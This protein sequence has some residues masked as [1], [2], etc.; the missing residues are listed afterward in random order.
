MV[1]GDGINDGSAATASSFLN[2]AGDGDADTLQHRRRDPRHPR[3][4]KFAADYKAKFS[5]DPGA[6]S[7]PAYACTQVFLAALKAVGAAA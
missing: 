6:Y 2:I 7:A 3:P 4:G 5:T 1:G